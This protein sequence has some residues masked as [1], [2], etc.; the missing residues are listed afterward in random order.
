[1]NGTHPFV[2]LS[3]SQAVARSRVPDLPFADFRSAILD[4]VQRASTLMAKGR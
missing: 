1:M 2:S 4:A 3:N